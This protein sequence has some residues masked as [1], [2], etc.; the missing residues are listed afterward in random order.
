MKKTRL[1]FLIIG[2]LL[3]ALFLFVAAFP[4]VF[5]SYGRKQSF[6][7][8]L[9]PCTE[10]I[11]GTNSLGYDVFTELV[12]GT[13]D[14]VLVGV[15]SSLLALISGAIIGI[16]ASAKGVLGTIGNALISVFALL[17]RLVVLIVLAGFI[18]GGTMPMILLIAAFSWVSTAREVKAKVLSIK[19]QPYIDA[20]AQ[21]G[22]SKLHTA[23]RHIL[24]NMRDVLLSRFLVGVNACILMESTLSF[25]GFGDLYYPTWGVMISFAK[26]RG[27]IVRGAYAYLL[28]PCIAIMLLSVAFYFISVYFDGKR[29]AIENNK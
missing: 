22:Y 28:A 6:E 4:Q 2:L 27:A 21:Y 9:E 3:L 15:L 16:L 11:L 24:P 29:N 5:T 14:T 10:H 19:S 23:V 25:L 13:R 7:Q 12:Y 18:G 1:P 17:P 26:A 8:W 20:C